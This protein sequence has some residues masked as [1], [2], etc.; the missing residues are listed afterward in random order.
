MNIRQ[1]INSKGKRKLSMVTA[2]SYFQAKMAEEAGIDMILVGDSYGNTILG[3]ENT[4]PV[5]MEEMLIA[6][7]A[8]R[9]GA[10]NT[11]V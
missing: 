4:L 7:S 1:I 6:V 10:P 2:Y 9:R 3:Y 5:T 11:F 8:V